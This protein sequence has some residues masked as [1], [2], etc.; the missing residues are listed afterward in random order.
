MNID[1]LPKF[2]VETVSQEDIQTVIVGKVN[3][4]KWIG[5]KHYAYLVLNKNILIEGRFRNVDEKTFK[6]T[7]IPESPVE[8]EK[9]QPKKTYP[10]LDG[11]WGERVQLVLD[12]SLSWTK[13]DFTISRRRD[14]SKKSIKEGWDHEHCDI[15]WATISLHENISYMKSS[16]D[17]IV[18]LE[19]FEKYVEKQCIDFIVLDEKN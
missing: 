16:N 10:Y 14:G 3:R 15:C 2:R 1:D 13:A 17:D 18:C 9:I 12:N 4:W 8:R 5:E 19:C 11:Y 7:F 6:A